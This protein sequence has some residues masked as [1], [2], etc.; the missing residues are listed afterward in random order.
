MKQFIFE[1]LM[2]TVCLLFKETKPSLLDRTLD[3]VYGKG[4]IQWSKEIDI[5]WTTAGTYTKE[6]RAR[7]EKR[8]DQSNFRETPNW[9]Y[10]K[11]IL[12]NFV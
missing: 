6:F 9:L 11:S 8:L 7:F 12:R 10:W 1:F 3:F 5:E 2:K 4:Y